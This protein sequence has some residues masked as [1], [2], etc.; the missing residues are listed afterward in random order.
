VSFEQIGTPASESRKTPL[1]GD[2]SAISVVTSRYMLALQKQR[3]VALDGQMARCAQPGRLKRFQ[4][5]A[6]RNRNRT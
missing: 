2:S 5:C 6:S 4:P 3:G 1:Q